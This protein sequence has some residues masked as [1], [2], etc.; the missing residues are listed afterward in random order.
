MGYHIEAL[1]LPDVKLITPDRY[2]DA[3]GHFAETYSRSAFA[4]LGL[5]PVFVQ[6]NQSFSRRAGTLR[7]L[8]FQAPPSAQ[9]KLVRV[10]RGAII[11]VAVDARRGSPT[12]GH[13]VRAE[14]TSTS[15]RQMFVPRGF[16]HGFVTTE[17]E[18]EISYKVDHVYDKA[19]E[20]AI[21]WNDPDLSIDWGL[22]NVRPIVSERDAQA[23]SWADFDS[24]F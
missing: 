10:V 19:Q 17:D 12:F 16:L 8:H 24:P 11:D 7:G 20:G 5:D 22:D 23:I 2:E 9:A 21:A 13:W 14:L 3:R 1:A 6:D 15:G 18:T 4:D